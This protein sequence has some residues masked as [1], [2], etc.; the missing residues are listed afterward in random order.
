MYLEGTILKKG[1]VK[2]YGN[3]GFQKQEVIIQIEENSPYPQKIPVDI[4]K[5][6][7]QIMEGVNEGDK[8]KMD[9]NIRGNEWKD[10]IFVSIQGWRLSVIE[11][12]NATLQD[13][14]DRA[15]PLTSSEPQAD[16]DEDP[17]PF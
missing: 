2:T 16:E 6:N 3:N 8:V 1:D 13:D 15:E 10:K 5:R 4:V 17:L 11:N 7:L 14:F 12:G 9:I